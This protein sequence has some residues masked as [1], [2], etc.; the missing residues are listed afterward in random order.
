MKTQLR[1]LINT[2]IVSYLLFWGWNAIFLAFMLLGFAP[3]ILPDLITAAAAS[4]VPVAYVGYAALLI[5]IPVVCVILG[6]TVL[7]REPHKLF[8]LGYAVEGPLMLLIV[9]RFFVVR[10]LTPAL[11][12]VF[13]VAAV[14][15][16]TFVWEL[17]DKKI[18]G[19]GA[20]W[21][22]LRAVGLTLY[23]LTALYVGIWLAF[24]AL[25]IGVAMLRGFFEMLLNLDDVLRGLWNVLLDFPRNLVWIPFMV[26][27][28][29]TFIFS[30]T[31]LVLMPIAVP[32]LVLR[33]WWRAMKTYI[34]R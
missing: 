22:Q 5:I 1:R 3:L 10:E 34:A 7:R 31:L 16:V 25:P 2:G 11:T 6:L 19:R 28:A 23:A 30:A 9:I 29:A 20:G 18:D 26:F 32:I 13:V 33:G 14:G 24:Y 12:F 21:Q 8:A 17:L 27:G 15:M 4:I